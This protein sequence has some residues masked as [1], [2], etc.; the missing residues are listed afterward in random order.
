ML[1]YQ[2]MAFMRA[3]LLL[4][5]LRIATLT[6]EDPLEKMPQYFTAVHFSSFEG[7]GHA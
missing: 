1:A 4:H 7:S 5:L 3:N 6:W 2:P